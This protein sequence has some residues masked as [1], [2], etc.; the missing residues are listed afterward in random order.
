MQ[1]IALSRGVT[2]FAII[3]RNFSQ[4]FDSIEQDSD[5]A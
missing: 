3:L 2:A 4:S 1:P 5:Y